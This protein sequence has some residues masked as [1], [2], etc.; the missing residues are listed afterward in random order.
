MS[1]K[2]IINWNEV[3]ED[4]RFN[5]L[6]R[7][8]Q[9][10][11]EDQN[12]IIEKI[13]TTVISQG[14]K[15]LREYTKAFDNVDID[16]IEMTDQEVQES[17][18]QTPKELKDSIRNAIENIKSFHESFL[19]VD[20]ISI[21]TVSGVKCSV[22]T[23]PIEKIGLYVPAG[24]KP[25]PSTAMMLGVPSMIA[26]CPERILVSPPNENGVVDPTIVT[27]AN[28]CNINRIFKIGGAQAI[29]ALAFGTETV[30][31]VNKIFGPGNTWVTQAKRLILNYDA[32]VSIDM[33]AG[34]TEVLII[35]DGNSDPLYIAF[36]L[37]SQAEH[38]VDSQVILL[39]TSQRQLYKVQE[40][41]EESLK[42]LS[43]RDIAERAMTN[44]KFILVDSLETAVNISNEYAPEHLILSFGSAANWLPKIKS[45]GSVFLGLWSPESAGDYCSGTNHVLPTGG[46]TKSLSGISVASFQKTISVQEITKKGLGNLSNDIVRLARAEGLEAHAKAVEVRM[47]KNDY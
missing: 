34:P 30:P 37:L 45:A 7:P 6:E 27:V 15:K 4:T 35:S 40:Q 33:P 5:L 26:G 42:T 21:E 44:S 9:V 25:L 19:N 41:I 39:S 46:F 11:R 18:E 28:Y 1:L 12:E 2:E 20:D 43:T 13:F 36:D 22:V 24:N 32:S 16:S 29:A 17:I 47:S 3:S 23:R 10:I 31:Q 8:T 14:D 38:G